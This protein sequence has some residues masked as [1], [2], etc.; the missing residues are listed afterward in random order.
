MDEIIGHCTDGN[1]IQEVDAFVVSKNGVKQRITTT[2]GWEI[3]ILWRDGSTTWSKLKD[4]KESYPV[5]V[6]EYI[7]VAND[8]S[9]LPAFQWWVPYTIKK[10]DHIITKVKTSYWQK[11]HKYGLEIP[12]N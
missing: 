11:T 4:A 9:H 7:T 3:N 5:Q 10:R 6:A 1:E 12:K 2:V 8:I